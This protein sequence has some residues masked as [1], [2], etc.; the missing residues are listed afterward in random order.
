MAAA[1]GE[2]YMATADDDWL[3]RNYVSTCLAAL[4]ADQSLVSVAGRAEM[5]RDEEPVRVGGET[6]VL[7]DSPAERVVRYYKTVLENSG[8]HGLARRRTLLSIPPMPNVMGGDWLW[9]ASIAFRGKIQT[10]GTTQVFKQ[11]GGTSASYA[12]IAST[13]KLPAWQ[14]RFAWEAILIAACQDIA[15]RSPV[16]ESIGPHGR[17]MLAARVA[18]TLARK[19]Q[20]W[21]QWPAYL[22]RAMKE[23]VSAIA[24]SQA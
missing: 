15:Y 21:N 9:M 7:D 24:Q 14:G 2:I 22:R 11:D 16:Y 17:L 10:V 19:W 6:T 20:I 4:V 3:A 12:A 5:Y 18:M 8:F 23:H 13:L 1:S